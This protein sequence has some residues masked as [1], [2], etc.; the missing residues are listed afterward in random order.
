MNTVNQTEMATKT[1]RRAKIIRNFRGI[2]TSDSMDKTIVV[3]I[4]TTKVHP[5]YA[6]SVSASRRYK[7]HDEK[8][9]YRVGDTVTFVQCRPLSKDKRWRVLYS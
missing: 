8:N 7:V 4:G 6:K 1:A 2:V 5:K 3:V 9:Q